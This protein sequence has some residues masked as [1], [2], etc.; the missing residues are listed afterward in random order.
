MKMNRIGIFML[1]AMF[2]LTGCSSG[3]SL[4]SDDD[5]KA[6]NETLQSTANESSGDS[7]GEPDTSDMFTDRDKEIG[8]D[9]E[10]SASITLADDKSTCDSDAVLID[11]NT[12][13]ITDEGTYI[14]SGK[15]TDGMIIVEAEDSDK[16]QLV[17]D[18]VDITNDRSAAIYVQSA[19]K[20]FITTAKDSDNILTNGGTYTAIDDNNIDAVIFSKD[21]LTLNGAGT[22]TINGAAGHGVVSKDDLV[23]TSGTYDITA[24]KHGLSGKDSVRVA[25]GIYTITSGKDGIHASNT[26]DSS[27]GYIYIAGGKFEITAADDGMHADSSLMIEDG[28]IRVVESYEGLEGLS[29]DISG[30]D[31]DVIAS[32]DGLNAAG[33]NDS[34][35]FGGKGE[36]MFAVEEGAYIHISGGLLH[37]N[38]SGDGIDSNGDLTISGGETYVSGPVNDGNGSLDYNGE[39]VITG[40]IFV[41]AGSSGMAQNFG[42]S[43]TQGAMLVTMGAQAAESTISLKDSSGN[44]LISWTGDKEFTSVIVSCPEIKE[45]STYT[46]TAG[47]DTQEITM[48]SLIYGNGG[49]GGQRGGGTR[50]NKD[51]MREMPDGTVPGNA[52]EMP[53]GTAPGRGGQM[54]G[55]PEEAAPEWN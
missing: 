39:G 22:L 30:G 16:I 17:L 6:G 32:D 43:S 26:D 20:V 49:M 42:S 7:S 27:L 19:D 51:Q 29:I 2:L 24:E 28:T 12:I 55:Q 8:Y 38:A 37:V 35:G 13:T 50:G 40:G 41:A 34:S 11:E 47:S 36:D 15:L 45:G 3:S 23:L 54:G 14:L 48:D 52:G 25:D 46:L 33:G 5:T 53:D 9:E 31:I 18:G 44:E 1:T 10:S 4:S 21:D